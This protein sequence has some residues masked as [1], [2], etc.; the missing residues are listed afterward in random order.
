MR[1][2]I[3][4]LLFLAVEE[5][6]VEK[7]EFEVL[8]AVVVEDLLHFFQAA[9][10]QRVLEVGVPDAD[11]FEACAS[12]SFDAILE[13]PGTIFMIGVRFRAAASESP[14]RAEQ[15]HICRHR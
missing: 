8:D 13:I 3:G 14:I 2:E 5:P 4:G 7:L 12:S 15:V 9:L 11:A 10:L 1:S 6:A